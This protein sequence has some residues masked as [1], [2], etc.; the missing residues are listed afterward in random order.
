[1]RNARLSHEKLGK[2]G[3]ILMDIPDVGGNREK[4]SGVPLSRLLISMFCLIYTWTRVEI[5]PSKN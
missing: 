5:K 1:M 4:V 2:K 3:L